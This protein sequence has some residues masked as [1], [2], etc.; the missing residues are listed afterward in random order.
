VAGD[1]RHERF[2]STQ[3]FDGTYHQKQHHPTEK[4][5]KG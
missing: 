1:G 5:V 4:D 2:E 3:L